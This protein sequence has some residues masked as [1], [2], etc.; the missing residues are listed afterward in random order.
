MVT[1]GYSMDL[2]CDCEDC[3]SCLLPVDLRSAATG[4]EEFGGENF[5]DTLATAKRAGWKFFD[6]FTGCYAPGHAPSKGK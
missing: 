6:N 4:F 3:Q 5:R 1:R 2:Y